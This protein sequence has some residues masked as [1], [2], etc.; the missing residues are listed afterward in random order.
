[1]RRQFFTVI[2]L[3][4][5]LCVQSVQSAAVSHDET[6]LPNV[7][8][9][10]KPLAHL[11]VELVAG[12]DIAPPEIL[13]PAGENLHDYVLKVSDLKRL[14]DAD[15]VLGFGTEQGLEK[16]QNKLGDKHWM[17]LGVKAAHSWLDPFLQ[18]SLF[19]SL[20]EQ[21]VEIDRKSVV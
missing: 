2:G 18:A 10:I 8:V 7:I 9:T 5:L 11:V 6:A 14:N 20:A 12:S 4:A 19:T 21:L 1:M 3:L 15:V 16:L 13:Y 17:S